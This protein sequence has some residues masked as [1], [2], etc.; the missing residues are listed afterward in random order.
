MMTEPHRVNVKVGND[1]GLAAGDAFLGFQPGDYFSRKKV[2]TDDQ[3]GMVVAQQF[4]EAARVELIESKPAALVF[5]GCIELVI[6]VARYFGHLVDEVD[7][8]LGVK[9]TENF[10]R[11]FE[12]VKVANFSCGA[13][14]VEG[15]FKRLGRANMA[16]ASGD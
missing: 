6:K 7:V 16:R 5:P 8:S 11:E 4:N 12:R 2:C 14:L 1:D 3:I 10:V 15:F 9:M 13:G